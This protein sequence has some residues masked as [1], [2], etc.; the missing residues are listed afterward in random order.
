M[1]MPPVSMPEASPRA[2]ALRRSSPREDVWETLRAEDLEEKMGQGAAH[3]DAVVLFVDVTKVLVAD[4]QR[5]AR[6]LFDLFVEWDPNDP[7]ARVSPDVLVLDGQ[8]EDLKPSIWQTWKPDCEPPRFALEI[9]SDK[10]RAKDYELNPLRYAALGTEELVVFDPAPR[11][12]DAVPLQ[13]FRRSDRG[14]FLRVYAGPGPVESA[15]LKAW[16]VV[17]DGGERVRLARDEEGRELVPTPREQAQA[18][19]QQ[20][21]AATERAE[22]A[23]ARVQQLEAELARLRASK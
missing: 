19:R 13:V 9:V 22:T 10:S 17:T 7:R 15:V 2:P 3:G 6:V 5:T 12:M 1:Q 23:E 21:R 11:G 18:A 16:L 14:Q 20:A 8:P 4:Q